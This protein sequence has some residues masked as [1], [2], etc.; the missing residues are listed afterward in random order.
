MTSHSPS[1]VFSVFGCKRSYCAS[2]CTVSACTVVLSLLYDPLPGL[3][4]C[5]IGTRTVSVELVIQRLEA[6]T[7]HRGS[8]PLV[9]AAV[10]QRNL[11]QLALDICDAGADAYHEFGLTAIS[12]VG[13]SGPGGGCG[14]AA[15]IDQGREFQPVVGEN[16]CPFDGVLQFANVAGPRVP[17][18]RFDR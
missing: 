1:F 16:E 5:T 9:A 8:T 2:A 4:T 10:L 15:A 6:A 17:G 12:C 13:Q 3:G 7:Q 18:Q 11:D 14:N